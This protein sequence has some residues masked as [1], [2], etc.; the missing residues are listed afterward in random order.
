[1][2]E[3]QKALRAHG[4]VAPRTRK[5]ARRREAANQFLGR[6][7]SVGAPRGDA[8]FGHLR[9][10]GSPFH[11]LMSAVCMRPMTEDDRHTPVRCVRYVRM[12]AGDGRDRQKRSPVPPLCFWAMLSNG[13]AGTRFQGH[14]ILAGSVASVRSD[15]RLGAPQG[16]ALHVS[17]YEYPGRCSGDSSID[18]G[19]GASF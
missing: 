10:P 11:N 2:P 7:Y 12:T 17:R 16:L 8:D 3:Q 15:Y 6:A 5:G 9:M 18:R 13:F 1:M 4:H 19:L 14:R